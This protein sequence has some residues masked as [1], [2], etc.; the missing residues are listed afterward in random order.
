MKH[1]TKT[2]LKK[3]LKISLTRFVQSQESILTPLSLVFSKLPRFC[4]FPLYCLV[5]IQVLDEIGVGVASQV[6]FL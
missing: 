6:G 5:L 2:K 3:K 4:S 1:L